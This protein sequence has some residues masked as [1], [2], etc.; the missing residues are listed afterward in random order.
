MTAVMG[1]LMNDF[2]V[3]QKKKPKKAREPENSKFTSFM[4]P[5]VVTF[6]LWT[7]F[8]R[9]YFKILLC[10]GSFLAAIGGEKGFCMESYPHR[11]F[12]SYC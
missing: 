1:R 9:I 3:W 12:L 8:L 4:L 11:T 5:I 7:K 10:G 6:P 2:A